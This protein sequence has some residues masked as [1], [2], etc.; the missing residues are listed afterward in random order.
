MYRQRHNN[1]KNTITKSNLKSHCGKH[2]NKVFYPKTKLIPFYKPG[3]EVGFKNCNQDRT[4]VIDT[5]KHSKDGELI[6]IVQENMGGRSYPCHYREW[7]LYMKPLTR[8]VLTEKH[9]KFNK[10]KYEGNTIVLSGTTVSFTEFSFPMVRR[11]R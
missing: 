7:E 3:D 8:K 1:L 5:Y 9:S 6:Y 4:G 11:W 10:K 2:R